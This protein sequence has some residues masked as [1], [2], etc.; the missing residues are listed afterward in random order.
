MTIRACDYSQFYM[1][2]IILLFFLLSFLP[3]I[4]GQIQGQ[5]LVDSLAK[6]LPAHNE[7]MER[8]KILNGISLAYY[9]IDPDKGIKFGLEGLKESERL[10]WQQ[11]IAASCNA[12]G[13]NYRVK[14]DYALALEYFFKALK[15]NE[16]LKDKP[17]ISNNLSNIGNI[18][19]DQQNYTKALEYDSKALSIDKELNNVYGIAKNMGNMGLIYHAVG[20][21]EKALEYNT[22]ALQMN[23]HLGDKIGVEMVLGNIGI[24]YS[25]EKK[26]ELA[27]DCFFK[28]LKLSSEIGDND[29][30]ASN[31]GN[32]G[33]VY[34][35]MSKDKVSGKPARGE[36]R[37]NLRQAIDYLEKSI[38]MYRQAG[39]T[40]MVIEFYPSLADAYALNNNA[41]RSVDF[42][43]EYIAL[44]DS[45][46]STQSR[47]KITMLENDRENEMKEKQAQMQQMKDAKERNERI[48]Y[49]S[50]LILLIIVVVVTGRSYFV[51]KNLN[52]IISE[53][54]SKQE[55]TI[56]LR[57]SELAE[58]NEKLAHANRKLVELIQYNAHNMREPLTRV[59]GA[60]II[61]EYMTNEDFYMEVWP[62]MQK[63]VND[64]DNS[65]K[66]V[67]NRAD[68]T[69]NLYG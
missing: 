22:S 63:A 33:S 24:I 28:A 35:S 39:N 15:I 57:T 18:Y 40:Q 27:L 29:G 41:L 19:G 1:R 30:I 64:L 5:A 2:Y 65:I 21:Y 42:Y 23:E 17:S 62:Q 26:Y 32:I 45:V 7:G 52:K 34:L 47:L 56:A 31:T 50:C 20:N 66:D 51:Q 8:V 9:I 14:S 10:E 55:I 6:E 16:A 53:L 4:S 46:F 58:S 48:F 44:K 37:A 38:R 60:M 59:M 36:V 61:H 12:L 49:I 13:T 3:S 11:G 25:T 43:R 69:V 67:I 54:V 68:E